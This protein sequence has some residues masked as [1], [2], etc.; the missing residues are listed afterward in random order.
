MVTCRTDEYRSHIKRAH[1]I[2]IALV[3][4]TVVVALLSFS[5]ASVDIGVLE[6]F[7]IIGDHLSGVSPTDYLTSLKDR[8]VFDQNI[9]RAIGAMCAGTVLAVSGA[10]LQSLIRNPLAEPY[11]LGISS[12]ALFGMVLSVSMGFSVVPFLSDS[13]SQ[14]VNAFVMALIP[15]AVVVVVAM[16]KKVSP[17]MMILCG[18][19]VMYIFTALTTLIRY[20]MDPDMLAQ[21]YS[22]SVGSVSG[23]AWGSLPK[24]IAAVVIVTGPMMLIHRKIDIVAQGDEEAIGLGINP[25]RLRVAA[26]VIVSIATAIIVCYTGTIGFV[27]LVAPHIAR[28]IVGSNNRVLIPCSAVMGA[29]MVVGSDYIVRLIAPNLPVGV[30]LAIVCSPIFIYILIRM[31]R[32]AW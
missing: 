29:L 4:A 24:M 5:A 10:V 14:I 12:G 28:I 6:S 19:A 7:R 30:I 15:T 1:R 23:I 11:T 17:T 22:W 3:L 18:I 8:I 16:F 26:L 21:V 20:T 27:G 32:S 9:P 2:T 13:D 25:N 31:R